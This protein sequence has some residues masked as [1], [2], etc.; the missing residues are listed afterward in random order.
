MK[1]SSSRNLNS[2]V[3]RLIDSL[4]YLAWL[5]WMRKLLLVLQKIQPVPN[6]QHPCSVSREEKASRS[7]L[8]SP[9]FSSWEYLATFS[10][11]WELIPANSVVDACTKED[12]LAPAITHPWKCK[13]T[14]CRTKWYLQHQD[15]ILHHF[16]Q[17]RSTVTNW[18]SIHRWK[19]KFMSSPH[20]AKSTC[21]ILDIMPILQRFILHYSYSYF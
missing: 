5:H 13:N 21:K 11:R 4:I 10:E 20:R 7:C 16:H 8:K 14:L 3:N 2:N 18:Q 19:M 9:N 17:T 1:L 15:M 12:W 6:G